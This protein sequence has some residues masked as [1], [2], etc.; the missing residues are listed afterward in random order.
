M[1]P[2]YLPFYHLLDSTPNV[3]PDSRNMVYEFR[4]APAIRQPEGLGVYSSKVGIIGGL[5]PW[6]LPMS[7]RCQRREVAQG[8]GRRSALLGQ[9]GLS[10]DEDLV[11]TLRFPGR[12]EIWQIWGMSWEIQACETHGNIMTTGIQMWHGQNNGCFGVG[13]GHPKWESK[14][15]GYR[16]FFE[17]PWME[18]ADSP[19]FTKQNGLSYWNDQSPHTGRLTQDRK[20]P[21][22]VSGGTFKV[23]VPSATAEIC[24]RS[25]PA[26]LAAK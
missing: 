13:C 23:L 10:V 12:I 7:P 11:A 1:I 26:V 6:N 3:N 24:E 21:S 15:S 20:T 22:H 4:R 5:Y 14:H 2:S 18:L 8:K 25:A 16:C 17:S 19:C 9:Q